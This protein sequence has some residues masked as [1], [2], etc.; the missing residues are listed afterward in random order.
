MEKTVQESTWLLCSVVGTVN[1]F[2]SADDIPFGF[3]VY[4]LPASIDM[5]KIINKPIDIPVVSRFET[6]QL[7]SLIRGFF[8]VFDFDRLFFSTELLVWDTG[9]LKSEQ[10]HFVTDAAAIADDLLKVGD[11]FRVA[12]NQ[13]R[14]QH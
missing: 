6:L 3:V 10:R 8:S 9:Y 14:S 1:V 11:D 2:A 12:I 4:R 5:G 13:L 7:K